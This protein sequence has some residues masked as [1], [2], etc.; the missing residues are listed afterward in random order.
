MKMT[1]IY[2][3][4]NNVT[5]E[6]L[7]ETAV[8]KED[9]TNIVDIGVEVFNANAVDNYVKSLINH[10]GKVVFVDRP[11]Q[12]SAPSVLMD[13]WEF[14]S[15][16]EK[17]SMDIPEAVKNDSWDLQNGTSYDPNIFYK[18]NVSAKFFNSKVTFEVPMSF[19]TMQVK[20][21]FSNA[22]QL[23]GFMSMIY[24]AIDKSITVKVDELIMMTINN[25]TAETIYDEY[26]TANINT[27]SS[28]KA[29]NLLFDYNKKYGTTLTAEKA[30]T[31]QSFLRYASY[32]IGLYTDRL[33]KLSKLFNIGKKDRFTPSD[34]MHLVMLS[35]F[36][37]AAD[38]FLQSET[39]HN[40]FTKLPN[41]ETVPF[42][43]GSGKTYEF[44][45]ITTIDVKTSGGHNVKASG[46]LAVIFDREALGVTNI[47]KR[48]TVN[49]NPKAEFY[50][51]WHKYDAGYFNDLNENFVV[52]LVA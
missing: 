10:I 31:D 11:Y 32:Q 48:V 35:D 25:M 49:Y 8:V 2:E 46:I 36:K 3:I 22:T 34:K 1:Q 12:G 43:Q 29:V 14:G 30:L 24:N 6:V 33:Q 7:G 37:K 9:L 21:S 26:K 15:V 28:V 41:A 45:D 27:K 16:V 44:A 38:V 52:F 39:F 42:W 18:P 17:I 40:E 47:D 19:T 23:N 13:G 5:K 4:M 51:N 20:E 50:N